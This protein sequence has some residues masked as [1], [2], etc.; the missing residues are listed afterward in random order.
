MKATIVAAALA[1]L[2][3]AGA[4]LGSSA[5]TFYY[6]T[7]WPVTQPC[8]HA[9]S[10]FP[11]PGFWWT[12]HMDGYF[13]FDQPT[14][15]VEFALPSFMDYVCPGSSTSYAFYYPTTGEPEVGLTVDFGTCLS[16]TT[17]VFTR[18][19][20][21]EV[22]CTLGGIMAHTAFGDRQSIGCDAVKRR[23]TD[24]SHCTAPPTNLS[25]PNGA[26]DVSVTPTFTC[27]WTGPTTCPEGIGLVIYRVYLGT[28]P[29]DLQFAGWQ[30]FPQ[31]TVGV[32]EPNT[33]YY[34]EMSVWDDFWNCPGVE[35]AWSP[36]MSFTTEDGVAAEPK[37]WSSIKARYKKSE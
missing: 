13:V 3:L 2:P 30:D 24:L 14:S 35:T 29:D 27:S 17:L 4:T 18:S 34:W 15:G 20:T 12:V 37:T 33:T 32:L 28:D 36:V 5:D 22:S 31:V 25:P 1:V 21:F 11:F 23:V 7:D 26:T 8:N 10:P 16:G 9:E 19:V 6:E